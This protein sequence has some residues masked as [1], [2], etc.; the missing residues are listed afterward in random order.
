PPRISRTSR[1]SSSRCPRPPAPS[2][3]V[4]WA[5]RPS[6]QRPRPSPTPSRT[7]PA[8][9]SPSCP[10]LRSGSPW[11]CSR[12]SKVGSARGG[13]AQL[14][15]HPVPIELGDSPRAIGLLA[16]S[17]SA[18]SVARIRVRD[19]GVRRLALHL[20]TPEGRTQPGGGG[21][22][23]GGASAAPGPDPLPPQRL[24]SPRRGGARAPLP[25]LF[26]HLARPR[27]VL[28]IVRGYRLAGGLGD[29]SRGDD[30]P[31]ASGGG[32]G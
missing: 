22:A 9:A 25:E 13:M 10:S 29:A 3:R 27:L 12:R 23:G 21:E 1:R 16:H 19:P 11:E 26:Q 6:S 8:C 31:P 32:A 30:T 4:A 5:S 15:A 18:R 28:Q 14:A 20:N 17:E 7:P 2:A 24:E